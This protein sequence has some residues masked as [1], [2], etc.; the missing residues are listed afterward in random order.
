MIP[1]TI[2]RNNWTQLD[3][4]TV[5]DAKPNAAIDDAKFKKPNG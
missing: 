1:F 4:L 5:T 3:T 2:K